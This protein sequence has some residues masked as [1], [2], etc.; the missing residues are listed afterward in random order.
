MLKK[1]LVNQFPNL[2]KPKRFI[3]A[4]WAHIMPV[5]ITYAQHQEDSLILELFDQLK[6]KI[7]FKNSVYVD[8]GANHPCDISNTYL[9]YRKGYHGIIIEPNLELLKLHQIFRK[10]DIQLGIGCSKQ[11]KVLK[12][13]V[14]KTPV[15][16]SFT[17]SLLEENI[18][19][20]EY[21]PVMPVDLILEKIIE[22][23]IV[24]LLSID[25]EGINFEVLESSQKTLVKCAIICVEFDDEYEKKL[26]N[27]FLNK[28]FKLYKEIYCNLIFL[29]KTY[30]SK[31]N[32]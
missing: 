13:N 3:W 9:F 30:F 15:L 2:G 23:R 16:S 31:L 17:E 18:D 11:A 4:L 7:D 8:I 5:R 25:V 27:D 12:F 21:V 22:D 28:N 19:H 29:N 6:H 32:D 1:F 20:I 10:N 14:S 24:S 26:I